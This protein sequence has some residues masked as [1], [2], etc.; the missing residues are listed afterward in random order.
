MAL[1]GSPSTTSTSR[2]QGLA[3]D[4]RPD[5]LDRTWSGS[6]LTRVRHDARHETLTELVVDPEDGDLTDVRQPA[7]RGLQLTHID[8]LSAGDDQVV[9]AAIE[10][11]PAV[12]EV[13]EIPGVDE[14][15]PPLAAPPSV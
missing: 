8:V 7:D 13:A 6:R 2:G 4:E 15:A 3:G 10:V 11:E 14:A 12:L 9:L 5:P 1:R